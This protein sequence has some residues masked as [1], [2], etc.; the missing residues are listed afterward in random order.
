[1]KKP[2][3]AAAALAA[4][5]SLSTPALAV[6]AVWDTPL[7]GF[8]GT[9]S[10]GNPWVGSPTGAYAEWNIFNGYPT[11]NTPDLGGT[12]SITEING[13]AFL[14]S[15]GNIYSFAAT[16]SFTASLPAPGA[17]TLFDVWL[18]VASL[19]TV[20]ATTATLN[21]VSATRVESY[22]ETITGGFG[23]EEKEWYWKWEDVAAGPFAFAFAASGS[24]M[25]LDQVAL[26]A[27]DVTPTSPIPEPG[28]V[29]LMLAGLG[30]LGAV[31]R[32]RIA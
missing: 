5:F 16:T 26:Y 3:V 17:G 4:A 27:Q 11:D 8:S 30:A 1:M 19:G 28:T 20:P 32:R 24:S 23:G 10:P 31:A 15:G 6:Q 22:S 25:S 13:V 12:G 18:R 2:S 7:N 9:G 14:T 29:M 21:G